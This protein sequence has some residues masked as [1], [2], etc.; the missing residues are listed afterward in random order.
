MNIK[1]LYIDSYTK[2]EAA[3]RNMLSPSLKR[4]I[5]EI[6]NAIYE[7][8]LT[9]FNHP[10]LRNAIVH[11]ITAALSRNEKVL[12]RYAKILSN[13]GLARTNPN[14]LRQNHSIARDNV[15][16][17]LPYRAQQY[18]SDPRLT[19]KVFELGLRNNPSIYQDLKLVRLLVD[20]VDNATQ[21][22]AQPSIYLRN[23]KLLANGI[24]NQMKSGDIF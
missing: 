12:E 24:I 4:T 19:S 15:L 23:K 20:A 6:R 10:T 14:I 2:K 8:G 3:L 17:A 18:F 22:Q 1:K 11:D 9:D 21:A 5:R 7:N 16:S 13:K